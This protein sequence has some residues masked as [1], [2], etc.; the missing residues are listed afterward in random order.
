MNNVYVLGS[1]FGPVP[2]V[3]DTQESASNRIAKI[4]DH[5]KSRYKVHNVPVKTV[6]PTDTNCFRFSITYRTDEGSF[7]VGPAGLMNPDDCQPPRASSHLL[8]RQVAHVLLFSLVCASYDE[9]LWEATNIAALFQMHNNPYGPE[10]V[11][12]QEEFWKFDPKTGF[13]REETPDV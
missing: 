5:L 12:I 9:G 3:F 10:T 6:G 8:Y 2:E 13:E 7:H 11:Q 1:T 4:P